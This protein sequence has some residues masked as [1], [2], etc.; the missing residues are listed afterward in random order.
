MKKVNK[1]AVNQITLQERIQQ[2]AKVNVVNCG[3]CGDVIFHD[4]SDTTIKCGCGYS[5]DEP[6]DFPDF[7][8][9]GQEY[10]PPPISNNEV[11]LAGKF[12][13]GDEFE[14]H[15][16]LVEI[17]GCEDKNT[18]I[19]DLDSV[20]PAEKFERTFTVKEFLDIIN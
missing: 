13:S 4:L 15:D 10:T 14:V 6:S 3:S 7:W 16:M 17:K 19:D 11:E 12:L 8:C 1:W 9:K 18:M 5:S 2:L 20:V